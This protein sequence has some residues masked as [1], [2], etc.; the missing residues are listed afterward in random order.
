MT[1]FTVSFTLIHPITKA[2][3]IDVCAVREAENK[4]QAAILVHNDLLKQGIWGKR[5]HT[6]V[7][8]VWPY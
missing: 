1:E 7:T 2:H 5:V 8:K 4:D 6:V 3:V